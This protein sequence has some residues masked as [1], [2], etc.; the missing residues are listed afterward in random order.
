M[1]A[2]F[3]NLKCGAKLRRLSL[4]GLFGVLTACAAPATVERSGDV[5]AKN[6][7]VNATSYAETPISSGDLSGLYINAGA[8]TPVILIVPGSGPTDLN[9]NNPQGGVKANTYK[10]LAEGLAAQ[11]ISTVRVDK[12]GMFSSAAA[13]D[14]N[15]VSLEI[16]AQDY[17]NWSETIRAKTGQPCV[18]MLGH[19]EG[20]LMVSAA[21]IETENVCGLILVS[22]MGRTYGDVIRGQ[23]KANPNN[24]DRI[25]NQGFKAI[26]QLERGERVDLSQ[27]HSGFAPLFAPEIQDYLISVMAVDPAQ[28]AARANKNTL[29]IHGVN[30]LQ[31]STLDAQ[32]LADATGGHLVMIK[33]MNHVLK[34]SPQ[35]R[36]RNFATYG[37]PDLPIS[38][39][40]IEAIRIFVME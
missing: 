26:E 40:V 34:N 39:S 1:R 37:K 3:I 33:G 7:D 30:D 2:S 13:G 15:A 27:L 38:E 25:L 14:G 18:Y 6:L 23:L 22:G 16:Y 20:A 28:L 35:N 21:S 24:P 12:R 29:V 9:G 36:R 5:T 32:K 19:S 31:T 11:G 10:L 8:A 17:K 4:A